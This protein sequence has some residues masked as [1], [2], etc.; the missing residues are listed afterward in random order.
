[1]S[2]QTQIDRL[3]EVKNRIRTNLVAQGITVP[4]DTML[5]EMATQIL[6]VAGE[7]GQR[8]TGL[9][10]VT[11]A[12][13]SYTT[14]VNG[15]T[16]AYRIALST[17]KTQASTAEVYAG[18]TLRYSYYH[19]PVIYVDASYVYCGT[20]VSIR[21]ATGGTGATGA[22][23]ATGPEGP[24]GYTPQRGTDYWTEADQQSIVQQ[25]ITVLGTPVF[26][27]VDADK[28]IILTGELADGT[29]TLKYE[30]AEGNVTEIGTLVNVKYIN[31]IP[32]STDTDG[33]IY[34]GVG[35]KTATRGNSSGAPADISNTSAPN[36][37]FFT[38]F[39]PAPTG[40]VIRL[41]NCFIHASGNT[42]TVTAQYGDAPFG[43]RSGLYNASKAKVQVESW[44]NLA[45][46]AV[47]IFSNYTPDTNNHITEF[48]VAA[49]GISFV[50]LCLAPTGDPADAIVTVNQEI[51]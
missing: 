44:G 36:A 50:R 37:V 7:D 41:K 19:Y 1:M 48:T 12:P 10:P 51:E 34:N 30:D 4:A 23:G 32:I 8:G 15:L 35:Y 20:R 21:G 28:N 29:Y 42:D 17:V 33:S 49:S 14:A 18:D 38:G 24:A 46:G 47:N 11:T 39:I 22:T 26:G 13:S 31:Q 6:S 40:S 9:L 3:N 43:L 5:D 16:P 25:V 45:S 2:V 27:R